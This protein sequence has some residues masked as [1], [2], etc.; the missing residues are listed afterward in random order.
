M[1]TKKVFT[2]VITSLFTMMLF[3]TFSNTIAQTKE[4]NLVIK[5]CC[6]MKGGKMMV[7]KDGV[8][9]PMEK[10]MT[11]KNGTVCMT[12]GECTMKDGSKMIMKNGDCMDMSGKMCN[13]KVKKIVKKRTIKKV[14]VAT[15]TCPMHPEVVGIKEGKCPKCKM[16][17]VKK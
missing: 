14:L 6:M 5:D 13:D 11:M 17:L 16:D 9:M 3:L 12:N 15:Y 1:K 10:E 4:K 2:T 7:M 8:F